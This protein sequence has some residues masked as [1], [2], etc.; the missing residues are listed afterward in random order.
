MQILVSTN[1]VFISAICFTLPYSICIRLKVNKNIEKN[2]KFL[3]TKPIDTNPNLINLLPQLPD[4][5][6]ARVLRLAYHKYL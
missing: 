2:F 6:Q 4:V 5:A 3:I 1:Q